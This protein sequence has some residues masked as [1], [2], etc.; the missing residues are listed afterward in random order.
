MLNVDDIVARFFQ[1]RLGKKREQAF[2]APVAVDDDD[3][4]AAVTGHFVGGFLQQFELE[5]PAVGHSAGL[6]FGF[7]NLA[8]KVFGKNDGVLVVGGVQSGVAHVDEV[9]TER[10]MR[11]VLFENAEGQ[12]AN[13]LGLLDGVTELVG[14]Q[15][16]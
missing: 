1:L 10:E 8:V 14:T 2:V 16:L 4:F 7:E 15:F 9:G 5:V 12:K 6:V 11:P 13:A 3:F